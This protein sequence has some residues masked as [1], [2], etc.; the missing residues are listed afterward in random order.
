VGE[1]I[2]TIE[3]ALENIGLRIPSRVVEAGSKQ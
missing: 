1:T 3:T 2:S